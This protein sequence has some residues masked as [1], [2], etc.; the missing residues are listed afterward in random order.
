MP[1]GRSFVQA[2]VGAA[3][4]LGVSRKSP[5]DTLAC[6]TLRGPCQFLDTSDVLLGGPAP[7]LVANFGLLARD[8]DGS[9]RY[10]CETELGG[11]AVRARISPAGE[12]FVPGDRG[13]T[14]LRPA[15][16]STAVAGDVA[17]RPMLQ[18][19]FD[20]ADPAHAWALGADGPTLYRSSDGGA[21]FSAAFIFPPEMPV[22]QLAASRGVVYGAGERS[23]GGLLLVRSDDGGRTFADVIARPDGLPLALLGVD[24]GDPQVVLVAMRGTDGA[25]AVWRSRDG[26]RTWTRILAL[27]SSEIL[28]GFTFGASGRAL[29]VA[30]RAQLFLADRPPASLY[31]SRDGGDTWL[32]PI[33]STDAGPRYRCLA[34]GG[35]ALHACAG[36]TPNGDAF[37]LGRS[38]DGKTWTPLMT[39]EELAGAE[40]CMKESCAAT[41]AWLCDLYQLCEGKARPD[42]G[43]AT[44]TGGGCGC[45]VGGRAPSPLPLLAL[46]LLRR[47]RRR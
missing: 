17:G 12:I 7:V 40:A 24:P 45:G 28:A 43:T 9:L 21:S 6:R 34:Y 23:S 36:G 25:D 18:V 27:P 15:C 8:P 38:T 22:L 41:S 30:G 5:A 14:R 42:A 31:T 11:L 1:C 2:A 47:R 33:P 26:G 10:G 13:I 29:F 20:P 35:G 4:L 37:L 39:V 32:P 44:T 16:G 46:L 3:L 19:L